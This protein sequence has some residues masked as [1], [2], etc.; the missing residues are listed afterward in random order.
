MR[1]F[2]PLQY[3]LC[4][5][6]P[7]RLAPSQWAEH[8][9]FAMYLIE[10]L[11][12]SCLVELGTHNGVS[13]CGFCQ[14]IRSAR[15]GARAYAVDTW[16]G[17]EHSGVY[18]SGVLD[19]L[20]RHHDPLYGDFSRLIQA[21]FDDVLPS[22]ADGSIDLLHIDGFHTYEAV[23]HDFD[24]WFSKVADNG[25]VLLHDINVR[26][27]NFGAWRVWEEIKDRLP[28]F[29]F[30]H[31]HGLGVLVKGGAFPEAL[32]HFAGN[33][34]ETAL[35]HDFFA[36][37]G[38][39]I[40]SRIEKDQ[41]V[42][43]LTTLV[44]NK[45]REILDNW[46]KRDQEIHQLWILREQENQLL[47]SQLANKDQEIEQLRAR[48]SASEVATTAPESGSSGTI[49]NILS[50]V[51]DRA[52]RAY[53][54][55]QE[56]GF[57][58]VLR[59]V[60]RRLLPWTSASVNTASDLQ[61]FIDNLPSVVRVGKGTALVL[62]GACYHPIERIKRLEVVA[63]GVGVPAKLSHLYRPDVF[64]AEH[65]QHDPQ[66]RSL[67][68]GF[69]ALVPIQSDAT[70]LVVSMRAST[71]TGAIHTKTGATAEVSTAS[72]NSAPGPTP[73]IAV[74]MTTYN[75]AMELFERQI[76]SIKDQSI[77]DWV[78]YIS[79]DCSRP[80]IFEQILRTVGADPRFHVRQN[81]TC[82]GFYRNFEA[83]MEM[84]PSEVEF[85]ALSDHDDYWHPTKLASLH[86]EFDDETTLVYSDMRIVDKRGE[87]QAET[88]WI[89]RQ[90]NYGSLTSLLMANTI[91]GAASMFR[92]GLLDYLLPFPEPVGGAFHD[93]WLGCMA[94]SL[95]RIKYV[96]RPLYDYVQH[97]NNVLGFQQQPR[98]IGVQTIARMLKSL[99]PFRTRA[100]LKEWLVRAKAIYMN[101]VLRIEQIATTILLRGGENI[102]PAKRTCL[103]RIARLDA[104]LRSFPWL[105]MRSIL[106]FR[107]RS[108]TMGAENGLLRALLWKWS[109]GIVGK[110][111]TRRLGR[112]V[113][114]VPA[115]P[116]S[117]ADAFAT[118]LERV[119][120]IE[121]KVVPLHVR[122]E[123]NAHKRVN[124]LIPTI[125]FNYVFGGYIT[126]FHLARRLAADGHRVR[127]VLVDYSEY[128]PD[129]WRRQLQ[130][131]PGLEKLLDCVEIV[132]GFDRSRALACHPTDTFIATTWWTAHIA[133]HAMRDL[134]RTHFVYL[135]QEFETYTFPMGTYAALADHSYTYP[136]HAVFSTE[137]LREHFRQHRLGCF[138]HD[139][140]DGERNS[141]AF[142]NAITAV[143]NVT[144]SE[145]AERRVKKLLFYARPEAHAARNMFEL[146]VAGL[147]RA[148]A[149]G[150]FTG[151][152]EFHGIGTVARGGRVP[153]AG[154][155]LRLLPRQDQESYREVPS[156]ARR[157]PKSY[158]HAASQPRAG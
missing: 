12:P 141:M 123:P 147:R 34:E 24:T 110:L 151:P 28:S 97:A 53:Q 30:S 2:N 99:S 54:V 70:S 158:V 80:E 145:L 35:V 27:G 137:F 23:R 58:V 96:D 126:K 117:V 68:S 55:W 130:A 143:G 22:F 74:C 89:R 134:G 42:Q 8:V 13:Y 11:R 3:P 91:T 138:A 146:G 47:W 122:V 157:G 153:L 92:R 61:V 76:Q 118:A 88:Y 32:Q 48:V 107:R 109:M 150:Y 17:D 65:P 87:A 64:Q 20:K 37:L 57:G 72:A 140:S 1:H 71:A 36:Q 78:C 21:K 25:V 4:L 114:D 9:P 128:C 142:A 103:E 40:S 60:A 85:I 156:A 154:A 121:Q 105:M 33:G 79:D 19:D 38:R 149:A 112:P 139:P 14:A 119:D 10:A 51:Q 73:R 104:S 133:H 95:G 155:T 44:R 101:D 26:E 116:A 136:H 18:G 62:H 75:P 94:L 148:V 43:E 6:F 135:I 31:Q 29:A 77:N 131:Y 132:C 115:S 66:G 59:K 102:T 5:A 108:V 56:Q 49:R 69:C 144:A 93:H 63:N 45:E 124:L 129:R 86:A 82:L 16:T 52:L 15:V 67:A 41:A 7:G 111:R 98:P 106:G 113:S 100:R 84:V 46:D 50:R 125:D 81:Q 90:N 120:T 152:W 83:V 39:R 127:I